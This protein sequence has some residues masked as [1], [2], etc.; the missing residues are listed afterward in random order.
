MN[1]IFN[2]LNGKGGLYILG[3]IVAVAFIIKKIRTQRYF[4]QVE[5]SIKKK[6]E[7]K[8]RDSMLNE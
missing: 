6:E 1:E 8:K 4:R 7:A 2:Y 5:K 3:L